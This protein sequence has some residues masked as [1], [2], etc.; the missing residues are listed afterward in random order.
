MRT[1]ADKRWTAPLPILAWAIEHP[2]GL[3]VVDA[4]E[5]ARATEPGYFPVWTR[6]SASACS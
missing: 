2:E 3:I 4:G 1:L 5:T 6:T